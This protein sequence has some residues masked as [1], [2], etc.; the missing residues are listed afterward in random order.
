MAV[1]PRDTNLLDPFGDGSLLTSWSFEDTALDDQAVDTFP[2]P[3]AGYVFDDVRPFRG[4]K[5]DIGVGVGGWTPEYPFTLALGTSTTISF[6]IQGVTGT[7][8]GV[9]D[10]KFENNT[11][12]Y[13]GLADG[14]Y[15]NINDGVVSGSWNLSV[16]DETI[17]VV[18]TLAIASNG[19]CRFFVDGV[20]GFELLGVDFGNLTIASWRFYNGASSTK[21][22]EFL[23]FT[24][25]LTDL[26]IYELA[27]GLY[28]NTAYPDSPILLANVSEPTI[29]VDYNIIVPPPSVIIQVPSPLLRVY[30]GYV[31][32]IKNTYIKVESL[33]LNIEM[34]DINLW[35][36]VFADSPILPIKVTSSV[37]QPYKDKRVSSIGTVTFERALYWS[38]NE[39]TAKYIST[40]DTAT[41][42]STVISISAL[43]EF[44]Q[45]HSI[46]TSRDMFVNK[47]IID[48]LILNVNE[49]RYDIIFTDGSFLT[50]KND[51]LN[52]PLQFEPIFD[53]SDEYYMTMG[54]LVW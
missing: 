47:T 39:M 4:K 34:Q 37:A 3:I 18:V 21:I 14:G 5:A 53:G 9:F 35:D 52:K 8:G 26:E 22:D 17:P 15:I 41:D 2:V 16:V 36:R 48:A 51:L 11:Y 45:P 10:I 40:S 31:D 32:I 1:Y 20:F 28:T 54:V 30:V 49:A 44:N 19:D 24:R 50:V 46:N 13:I 6:V 23:F 25:N 43:R 12:I 7:L 33:R 29:S 38:Q 42:G 27:T